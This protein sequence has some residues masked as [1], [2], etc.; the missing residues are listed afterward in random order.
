[1]RCGVEMMCGAVLCT[2]L[3]CR[4]PLYSTVSCRIEAFSYPSTSHLRSPPL[5]HLRPSLILPPHPLPSSSL[6]LSLSLSLPTGMNLTPHSP[7][8]LGQCT[9]KGTSPGQQGSTPRKNV[10]S[11]AFRE[12]NPYRYIIFNCFESLL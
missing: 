6:S 12:S 11:T 3:T 4:R 2:F 9:L 7:W 5:C 1:M 10:F 8:T